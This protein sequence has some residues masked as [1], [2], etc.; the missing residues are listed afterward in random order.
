MV[1]GE[2][3]ENA[4]APKDAG[5]EAVKI[6]A[7]ADPMDINKAVESKIPNAEAIQEKINKQEYEANKKELIKNIIGRRL[8]PDF[9]DYNHPKVLE[10]NN[11]LLLAANLNEVKTYVAYYN[12]QVT[13]A[14][15]LNKTT[16]PII[17]VDTF[18]HNFENE[19]PKPE[20]LIE[21]KWKSFAMTP[22]KSTQE[23]GKFI[24]ISTDKQAKTIEEID[25]L[26]T[27]NQKINALTLYG[28]ADAT[29]VT[30]E[31]KEKVQEKF[32]ALRNLLIDKWMAKNKL[33]SAEYFQGIE[34]MG[35]QQQQKVLNEWWAYARA[36]MQIAF[37]PADQ[38]KYINEN[39]TKFTTNIDAKSV[40]G[41]EKW[42]Q[43]TW[44]MI[45]MECTGSDGILKPL[46]EKQ[47]YLLK[48]IDMRQ[49]NYLY[50]IDGD[51]NAWISDKLYFVWWINLSTN[52][53]IAWR[54]EW[55]S[56]FRVNHAANNR[57]ADSWWYVYGQDAYLEPNTSVNTLNIIIPKNDPRITA[58]WVTIPDGFD[59]FISA[60]TEFKKNS[61]WDKNKEVYVESTINILQTYKQVEADIH[62]AQE[63]KKIIL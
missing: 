21:K 46:L 48:M 58:A 10:Y 62:K 61:K 23:V 51:R 24:D 9:D 44:G 63:I 4:E 42:N 11:K 18:M 28:Y 40:G 29:Q 33:P 55:L 2:T 8:N 32:T 6:I 14:N 47:N 57:S 19:Q 12:L 50:R 59:G 60:L 35:V 17:D 16:T 45:D 5:K 22:E 56:S 54:K 25:K 43:Y 34:T 26:I 20:K 30:N 37:L 38:I 13:K 36:M 41:T 39:T 3:K 1:G 15:I 53:N 7:A 52:T 31:G 27:T 49:V